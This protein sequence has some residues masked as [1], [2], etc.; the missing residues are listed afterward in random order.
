M[1]AIPDIRAKY[2]VRHIR[3]RLNSVE[4]V[5]NFALDFYKD[6]SKTYR[7]VTSQKNEIR[8]P[9]G[10]SLTD[11][12]ILGLLVR[13]SKLFTLVLRYYEEDHGEYIGTVSRPLLEAS[14]MALYLLQQDEA[15]VSDYRRCSYKDALRI[16]RDYKSGSG[17][18][19]TRAGRRLLT[20]VRENL[21]LEGLTED[22]FS[23]QKR[24]GW[25]LQGKN[26]F[27]IFAEMFSAEAFA[28]IYGITSES[29]HS[30]WNHS[31][32]WCLTRNEDG[33]FSAYCLFIPAD[34]R[35]ISSAVSYST[36]AY[37]LWL[38]RVEVDNDNL[39]DTLNAV[40]HIN[41]EIY[42]RFDEIFDG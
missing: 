32:D 1:H 23:L 24:N 27:R 19:R 30:S 34:V 37:R 2:E 41:S 13:I 3:D 40:E 9:T 6:V 42:R 8:N 28:F 11:A 18:F 17:F 25:R 10:Y 38:S 31:M 15:V 33:T 21:A 39:I 20:S 7:L 22:D 5:N 16:L 35:I 12:P 4:Q 14:I 29:I 26:F 36:P